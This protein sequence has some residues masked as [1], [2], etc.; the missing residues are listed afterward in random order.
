[1]ALSMLCVGALYARHFSGLAGSVPALETELI[2]SHTVIL[3][4]VLPIRVTSDVIV[5][6]CINVINK[7][8][9]VYD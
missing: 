6:Q 9:W 1:M 3:V 5:V 4:F 8:R 7:K 2:R